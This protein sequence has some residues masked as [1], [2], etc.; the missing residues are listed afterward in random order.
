VNFDISIFV[1]VLDAVADE[2]NED[3]LDALLVSNHSVQDLMVLLVHVKVELY[4]FALRLELKDFE[5]LGDCFDQIK[6]LE[7]QT[8]NGCFNLGHVLKVVD[9]VYEGV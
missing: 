3:L 2:V 5:G 7:V 6:L 4:V 9:Q 1:C 8:K